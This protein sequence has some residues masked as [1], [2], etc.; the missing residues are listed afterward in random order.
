MHP[1]LA[2]NTIL[3]DSALAYSADAVRNAVWH[4]R[5]EG[6]VRSITVAFLLFHLQFM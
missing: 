1:K 4:W 6:G 2:E 3:H 5:G